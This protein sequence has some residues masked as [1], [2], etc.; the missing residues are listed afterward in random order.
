MTAIVAVGALL[1]AGCA[2][3]GAAPPTSASNE[4]APPLTYE[5][6]PYLI[7]IGDTININVWRNPEL[8]QSIIVR[9]DGYISMPLMGDVLADGKRPEALADT[10]DSALQ[11]VIRSPEVTVMVT[12]PASAEY[13]NLV[14]VTG[15]VNSP[16]SIPYKQGMRVMDVVLRAGGVSEYG[17]GGRA[18]L[19]RRV[20]GQYQAFEV[21]LNAIFDDG[22]MSSNYLLQV[23]DVITVPEKSAWRGEF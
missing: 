20:N 16:V 15:E 21:D 10:I 14:R 23:D 1:L 6:E 12:S 11:S 3:N 7:G 2:S 17:A 8:S 18:K 5:T 22:D 19:N 13:L 9:P 4:G